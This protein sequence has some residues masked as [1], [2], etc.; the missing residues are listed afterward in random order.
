MASSTGRVGGS[1]ERGETNVGL[2]R[3]A[4]VA[5]VVVGALLVLVAAVSL[6]FGWLAINPPAP[7]LRADAD[8]YRAVAGASHPDV[9]AIIFLLFNDPGLDYSVVVVACLVYVWVKRRADMLPAVLVLALAM[10]VGAWTKTY[11][12]AFGLRERPFLLV[13]DVILPESWRDLWKMFPSFPSGHLRELTGLSVALAYY[14]RRALPFA[15]TFVLWIGFSR[16]YI[17]AHFPSDVIAASIVGLLAGVFAV[18]AVE[19]GRRLFSLLLQVRGIGR[20]REYLAGPGQE[21]AAS[22]SWQARVVRGALA[23]CALVAATLVL[24]AAIHGAGPRILSDYLRNV[25]ISLSN[26]ILDVFNDAVAGPLYWVFGAPLVT[27]PAIALVTLGYS[28]THGR[29]RLVASLLTFGV[30]GI[31][32]LFLALA[33][34]TRFATPGPLA[35]LPTNIPDAWQAI[36][37]ETAPFPAPY[38]T[39]A[40]ALSLILARV[41]PRTRV[42]ATAYPFVAAAAL[43]YLG[44]LWPTGAMG[45]VVVG[46]WL[47]RLSWFLTAQIVPDALRDNHS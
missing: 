42:V 25:D 40:T 37:P 14:W 16:V 47:A 35:S 21:Q 45:S 10:A 29:K 1:E 4:I 34:S 2:W 46:Y 24:A 27:Y 43:V 18:V 23:F 31:G 28:L 19:R 33:V 15:V 32:V 20:M 22:E 17:G 38:L 30:V 8:L 44:A 41:W 13:T 36:W 7:L 3:D 6:A 39:A 11:T 5:V 9:V 12:E 26:P